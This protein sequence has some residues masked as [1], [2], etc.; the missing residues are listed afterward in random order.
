MDRSIALYVVD[1]A[2]LR[3]ALSAGYDCLGIA[4]L[5]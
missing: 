5:S 1:D 2:H 3:I 4:A